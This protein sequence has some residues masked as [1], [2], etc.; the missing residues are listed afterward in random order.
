MKRSSGYNMSARERGKTEKRRFR[1]QTG[2]TLVEVLIAMALVSLIAL[3][4]Y[5]TFISTSRVT[6][7]IDRE[8]EYYREVRLTAD[9]LTRELLSAY[10]SSDPSAPLD[11][12]GLHDTGPEGSS[13]SLSFYTMA[14]LHLIPG[15]PESSLTKVRY[16]LEKRPESRWYHLNHEEYSHFLSAGPSEKEVLI[17]NV[18]EMSI[19]Y[20]DGK[21]WLPEWDSKKQGSSP[22]PSAVKIRFV[23]IN[24]N[25]DEEEWVR[26]VNLFVLSP[27]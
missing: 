24:R 10:R 8:R 17:E 7:S 9:Q 1:V 22:I 14:H 4:L 26:Q 2:F 13:D 23:L 11:F 3:F 20:F 18:K 5:E 6:E 16:Y 25:G 21:S 27:E 12:T 15:R 19:R